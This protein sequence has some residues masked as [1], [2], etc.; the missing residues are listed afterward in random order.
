MSESGWKTGAEAVTDSLRDQK[1]RF[2][3]GKSG[4]P[5]GR[6]TKLGRTATNQQIHD[7]ILNISAKLMTDPATGATATIQE[8]LILGLMSDAAFGSDQAARYRAFRMLSAA[9]SHNEQLVEVANRLDLEQSVNRHRA[10]D[11]RQTDRIRNELRKRTWPE[12]RH[13]P[14]PYI[15]P[16]K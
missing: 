13:K 2:K 15:P 5:K 1:G 11:Q 12:H 10:N 16:S 14:I 8:F 4:N 3:K 7:D 6:P 9:I